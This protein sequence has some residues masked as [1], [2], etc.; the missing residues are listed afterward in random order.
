MRK[1][2][3]RTNEA[4]FEQAEKRLERYAKAPFVVTSRLHCALP[5]LAMGTPMWFVHSNSFTTGRFGGNIDFMNRL[6]MDGS[7]KVTAPAGLDS[8]DGRIHMATRPAVRTE[9]LPFAQ[10]L[11]AQCRRFMSDES[12]CG[13][14]N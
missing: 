11:A 10:R 4:L 7:W 5:C 12:N 14:G 3:Y 2:A 13:G 6:E 1:S 8:A 9:H